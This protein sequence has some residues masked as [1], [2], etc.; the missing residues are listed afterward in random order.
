MFSGSA[1]LMIQK[2]ACTTTPDAAIRMLLPNKF[3]RVGQK[4]WRG[5]FR[6]GTGSSRAGFE[7]VITNITDC[8]SATVGVGSSSKSHFRRGSPDPANRAALPDRADALHQ[9]ALLSDK[10]FDLAVGE[11]VINQ[12]ALVIDIKS[13]RR[14][15]ADQGRSRRRRMTV[16]FDCDP[17]RDE[18]ALEVL[19]AFV[20]AVQ[21]LAQTRFPAVTVRPPS[22]MAEIC[23]S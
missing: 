3:A 7:K 2:V 6:R 17:D 18:G 21:K 4:L 15:F 23:A 16:V 11:G 12:R 10:L 8:P 1:R 13:F 9:I 20:V 19:D 5:S 22:K 14:S